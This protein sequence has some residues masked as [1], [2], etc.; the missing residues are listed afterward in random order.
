MKQK[1]LSFV[2]AICLIIPCAF[3]LVGCEDQ[4]PANPPTTLTATE[5]ATIYK[6]VAVETWEK[7][8]VNDP[9]VETAGISITPFSIPDLREEAQGTYEETMVRMNSNSVG[10]LYFIGLLYENSTFSLTNGVAKFEADSMA[11]PY[12]VHLVITMQPNIDIDNNKVSLKLITETTDKETGDTLGSQFALFEANYNFETHTLNTF[13][14]SSTTPGM[15]IDLGIDAQGKYLFYATEDATTDFA[16]AIDS[17][18]NQMK[19]AT[20]SISKLV[21]SYTQEFAE[22]NKIIQRVQQQIMG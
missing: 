6:D 12:E 20:A 10:I 16:V 21:D 2:L 22:Y 11:G 18:Y 17:S 19:T 4:P 3:A 13:R 8:G 15:Y 5:K 1:I 9:T 7:I 14:L